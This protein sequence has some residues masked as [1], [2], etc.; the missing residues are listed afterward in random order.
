MFLYHFSFR[1]IISKQKQPLEVSYKRLFSKISQYS[2]KNTCVGVF[3]CSINRNSTYPDDVFFRKKLMTFICTNFI[4]KLVYFPDRAIKSRYISY[5]HET[6][7]TRAC[8]SAL[9][10]VVKWVAERIC[11]GIWEQIF[12]KKTRDIIT[13]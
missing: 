9:T 13:Q 4:K 10:T 1:N 5:L 3:F 8:V 6:L 12:T 2:Q 7:W 11:V